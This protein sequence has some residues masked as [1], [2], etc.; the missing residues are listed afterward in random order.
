L[1]SFAISSAISGCQISVRNG[2]NRQDILR[3]PLCNLGTGGNDNPQQGVA[4][5]ELP[6]RLARDYNCQIGQ[7]ARFN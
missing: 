1:E 7:F 4:F 2:N 3:W 5:N 6:A